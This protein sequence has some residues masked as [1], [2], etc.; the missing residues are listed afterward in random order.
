MSENHTAMSQCTKSK[1]K[2]VSCNKKITG[3]GFGYGLENAGSSSNHYVFH[4]RSELLCYLDTKDSAAGERAK[5][6][7]AHI[8]SLAC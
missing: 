8:H 7:Q 5:G 3:A 2:A 4:I 6:F 1:A